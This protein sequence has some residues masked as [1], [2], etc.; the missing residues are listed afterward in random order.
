MSGDA[1]D[2]Q[3]PT[4]ADTVRKSQCGMTLVEITLT[5]FLSG[6]V[7]MGLTFAYAYGIGI[8]EITERK[9]A[10]HADGTLA[11]EALVQA[12]SGAESFRVGHQRL[13]LV[14]PGSPLEKEAMPTQWVI[15]LTEQKL[16]ANDSL[17]IPSPGDSGIAV[18]DFQVEEKFDEATGISVLGFKLGLFSKE[19]V[20][21]SSD[22]MWFE[23]Q[24]HLRNRGL[25]Q[26]QVARSGRVY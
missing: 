18:A 21:R 4:S 8:W 19:T 26:S 24:V 17:L 23:S 7:L 16:W 11:L 13:E 10:M 3:A 5:T 12:A 25:T 15:R 2:L 14:L 22:S 1:T 6:M 9:L 20:L